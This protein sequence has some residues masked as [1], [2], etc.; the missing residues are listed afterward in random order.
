M[1]KSDKVKEEIVYYAQRLI[2]DG[3]VT[4]PGGNISARYENIMFISPSG[5]SFDDAKPEDYVGV[6][7][8][9]GQIVEG[10]NRP[11]SEVLMHLGCY[12]KRADIQAIVHI[13]PPLA[14]GIIS[15]GMNL[16]PMYPDFYIYLGSNIPHIDYVTV[17]TPRL[18]KAVEKVIGSANVVLMRNHGALTVGS[19]LPQ[20]YY[21]AQI[22]EEGAKVLLAALTV[23]KPRYLTEDE[24]RELDNLSSEKYRRELLESMKHL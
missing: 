12:R 23:G 7:I 1:E 15:A 8:D 6:D 16:K 5:F 22:I 4:G 13:H 20:A 18:A 2:K 3:L 14:T 11:S 17:T 21:R 19:N 9:S 10:T 24:M